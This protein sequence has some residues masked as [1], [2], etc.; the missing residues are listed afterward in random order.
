VKKNTLDFLPSKTMMDAEFIISRQV[1]PSLK[2]D[3]ED[4]VVVK[5]TSL[6][7]LQSDFMGWTETIEPVLRLVMA[8][9]KIYMKEWGKHMRTSEPN[10]T[11]RRRYNELFYNYQSLPTKSLPEDV[12]TMGLG[13]ALSFGMGMLKSIPALLEARGEKVTREKILDVL[14]KN[15]I[16]HASTFANQDVMTFQAIDREMTP[17]SGRGQ[18]P[19]NFSPEIFKLDENNKITFKPEAFQQ[20][21]EKTENTIQGS[22]VNEYANA[23]RRINQEEEKAGTKNS[24]AHIAWKSCPALFADVLKDFHSFF[25]PIVKKVLELQE[26]YR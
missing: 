2:P 11:Y 23:T 22:S 21:K 8:S 10:E 26:E 14:S 5:K 19:T 7:K 17:R 13:T 24:S 6:R 9:N 25:E 20:I 3:E 4:K 18:E 12:L 16:S 1:I 15:L